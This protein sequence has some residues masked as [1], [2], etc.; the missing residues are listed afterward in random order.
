[1]ADKIS[2]DI[3]AF[4]ATPQPAD[5]SA[6]RLPQ[7]LAA[8]EAALSLQR[9]AVAHWQATLGELRDSMAT[10]SGSANRYQLSLT[11]LGTQVAGLANANR[12]LKRTLND[13]P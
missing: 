4:P 10:L 12:T 6:G 1:M 8:L 7:A 13:A 9:E 5:A 3:I 11:Q 2:A